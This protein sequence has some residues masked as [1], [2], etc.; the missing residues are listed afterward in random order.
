MRIIVYVNVISITGNCDHFP[1]KV[2]AMNAQS[3][4]VEEASDVK[5]VD[6]PSITR[7]QSLD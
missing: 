2:V 3:G 6:E 4:F 7:L 1:I 5:H